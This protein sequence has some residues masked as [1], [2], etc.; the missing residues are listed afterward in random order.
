MPQT[1]SSLRRETAPARRTAGEGAR[2]R[3]AVPAIPVSST[4]TMRYQHT[5]A[6]E[7]DQRSSVIPRKTSVTERPILRDGTVHSL[8]RQIPERIDVEVLADFVDRLL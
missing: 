2:A 3:I 6:L 4:S 8:E 1:R 7:I 5:A